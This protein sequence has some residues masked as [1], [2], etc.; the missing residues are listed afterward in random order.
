[1]NRPILLA[2]DY[3]PDAIAIQHLLKKAE[4]VNPIIVVPDGAEAIA[5]LNRDG[6]F[7]DRQKFP[8]PGVL[9]LDLKMPKKNG[10]EVLEWCKTQP[11]LRELFIVV[12]TGNRNI[13][14]ANL[15]YH[16]GAD[17]FL[18]KPAS[19]EDVLNAIKGHVGCA[20]IAELVGA[21]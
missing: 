20:P 13:R 6:P 21:N 11:H 5:Y 17:T 8:L 19:R 1:M 16:L 9:L 10:F 14:A 4:V 7:R 3:E 18:V 12:L 15:A 2:E